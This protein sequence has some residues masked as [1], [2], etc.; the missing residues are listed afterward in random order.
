MFL[1]EFRGTRHLQPRAPCNYS[2]RK[3]VK[4]VSQC[5]TVSL[6]DDEW[7]SK[8]LL[9]FSIPDKRIVCIHAML[10]TYSIDTWLQLPIRRKKNLCTRKDTRKGW[11]HILWL[12]LFRGK[13]L[14]LL[15][16]LQVFGSF[17]SISKELYFYH[18]IPKRSNSRISEIVPVIFCVSDIARYRCHSVLLL[19]QL[20][21]IVCEQE[22][23]FF[24]SFIKQSWLR[25]AH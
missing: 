13:T 12:V 10:L 9:S 5:K 20:Y 22:P 2:P 11:A 4:I 6:P 19:S 1:C 17:S 8:G 16:N 3:C 23:P 14:F 24:L 18:T 25:C 21:S 7:L 15:H